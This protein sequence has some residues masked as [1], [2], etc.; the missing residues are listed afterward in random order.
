MTHFPHVEAVLREWKRV[1]KPQGRLIFDIYSLDHLSFA[2]GQ[3]VTLD[4]LL[5]QGREKF[6]MHLSSEALVQIAD[7]AGLRIVAAVPYGSLFSGEYKHWAQPMPLQASHWW[8][9]QLSWL[10]T[11]DAMLGMGAFLEQHWF[12][13]LTTIT[14]GR[15]MV[16]LE[17]EADPAANRDWLAD[18]M[19]LSRSLVTEPIRLADLAPYLQLPVEQWREQFDRHLDHSRNRTLAY[20][21][22]TTFLG[23]MEPIDWL[24]LAPRN[25]PTLQRWVKAEVIDR[26]LQEF[27]VD[28]HR[29]PAVAELCRR[30]GVDLGASLDYLLLRRFIAQFAKPAE[31]HHS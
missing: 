8:K 3:E 1:V 9:R 18:Q 12:A 20:F 17:N 5:A 24:D 23:R 4:S 7:S 30:H 31:P 19:S 25:G 29:K 28:W 21:I 16:V 22:M 14:T 6:N 10:A 11:D 27:V 26:L 2:R 13:C 15:F